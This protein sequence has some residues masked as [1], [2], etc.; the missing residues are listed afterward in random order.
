MTF[1]IIFDQTP[2]REEHARKLVKMYF[3]NNP[4]MPLI[5]AVYDAQFHYGCDGGCGQRVWARENEH[6]HYCDACAVEHEEEKLRSREEA[7]ERIRLLKTHIRQI[8]DK[9]GIDPDFISI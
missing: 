6:P 9:L 8:E 4:I 5:P 3:R 2:D 7:L 1:K